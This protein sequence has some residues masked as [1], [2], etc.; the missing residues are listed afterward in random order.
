MKYVG[1][2]DIFHLEPKKLCSFFKVFHDSLFFLELFFTHLTIQC[3]QCIFHNDNHIDQDGTVTFVDKK[4]LDEMVDQKTFVRRKKTTF[5][6]WFIEEDIK[7][8]A[9]F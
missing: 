6:C 8:S 4:I 7:I 9:I 3:F 5:F 1:N 2:L